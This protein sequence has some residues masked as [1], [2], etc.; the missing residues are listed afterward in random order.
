MCACRPAPLSLFCAARSCLASKLFNLPCLAHGCN[1]ERVRGGL[2]HFDFQVCRH[3]QQVGA[4]FSD[5]RRARI[6]SPG[7]RL[8]GLSPRM[9][10]SGIGCWGGGLSSRRV[11][12][13]KR[14][15]LLRMGSNESNARRNNQ[16]G[17]ASKRTELSCPALQ[18]TF[19]ADFFGV[20]F[21]HSRTVRKGRIRTSKAYVPA[22][23][24]HSLV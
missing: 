3:F 15:R 20:G 10:G 24:A 22:I 18:P 7:L 19:R 9:C 14:K 17:K 6:S 16:H 2:V 4:L 12:R 11:D 5:L 21:C 23:P 8:I 13:R 1:R